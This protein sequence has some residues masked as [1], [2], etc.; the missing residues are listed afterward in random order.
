[1]P[2]CKPSRQCSLQHTTHLNSKCSSGWAS[3]GRAWPRLRR[4]GS[5]ALQPPR[6][7]LSPV[8]P[9][10]TW[11]RGGCS[12]QS[13]GRP[14]GGHVRAL[15][16]APRA[17]QR[18]QPTPPAALRPPHRD[19]VRPPARPGQAPGGPRSRSWRRRLYAGGAAPARLPA[20]CALSAPSLP[21]RGR[22]N[23]ARERK[24]RRRRGI[25]PRR[26]DSRAPGRRVPR[27]AAAEEPPRRAVRPRRPRGCCGRRAAGAASGPIGG[28]GSCAKCGVWSWTS[29]PSRRFSS[30]PLR[31]PPP[32]PRRRSPR[33]R[34]R[35]GAASSLRRCRCL[36]EPRVAAT[37]T[38]SSRRLHRTAAPRAPQGPSLRRSG[39]PLPSRLLQRSPQGEQ[40]G[41]GRG[42]GLGG[43]RARQ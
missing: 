34:R 7:L 37:P 27:R 21:R 20:P 19:R 6:L 12:A 11:R 9:K 38:L 22:A 33:T 14:R 23:V 28:G 29:C 15:L 1:M 17:R 31:R 32:L 10:T 26:R 16:A 30:P 18:A 2:D 40:R 41:R 39:R 3:S 4:G 35:V 25:A 42:R 36:T 43:G 5:G 24:W 13:P 8:Q